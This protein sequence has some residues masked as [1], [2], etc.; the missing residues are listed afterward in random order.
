[1]IFLRRV[2]EQNS[3]SISHF[4]NAYQSHIPWFQHNNSIRSEH[5]NFTLVPCH[6][7]VMN[8]LLSVDGIATRYWLDCPRFEPQRGARLSAPVHTA[9]GVNLVSYTMGI[10]SLPMVKRPERGVDHSPSSN[11]E[12]KDRTDLYI[13]SPSGSSWPVRGWYLPFLLSKIRIH[14]HLTCYEVQKKQDPT[15][16]HADLV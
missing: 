5:L 14:Q 16:R 10:G 4:S 15:F 2:S 8:K 9:P 13:Y 3:A 11:D 6:F 1:M 12:A 7:K